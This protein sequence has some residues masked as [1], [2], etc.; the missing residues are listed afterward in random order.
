MNH[1]LS[2]GLLALL[3][4]CAGTPPPDWA[5]N[6]H[7]ALERAGS[8]WLAGNTRVADAEFT[9]ARA[10]I[11]RTGQPERLARAELLRCAWQVA[12]LEA[13]D[14]PAYA[15]LA[16]D[17]APAEQAYAR[18]LLGKPQAGDVALLPDTQRT[19]AQALLAG[20]PA[21][22]PNTPDALARLV[23]AGV[24]LRA[25]QASPAVVGQAVDTASAQGW[26]RP[27]LAWLLVQAKVAEQAGDREG[28]ER[29]R[30]R[31][32]LVGGSNAR[33]HP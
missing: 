12:G 30:R 10:E 28:A 1:L 19:V 20:G 32:A 9:R 33:Q 7:G 13:T 18:Y 17:A 25:G 6:A 2:L 5:L 26:S 14:C 11:A 23:A 22:L 3:T 27:L 31:A 21:P 4:A 15:P 24:L 29:A 8:A 16:A